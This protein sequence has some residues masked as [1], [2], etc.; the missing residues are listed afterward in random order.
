MDSRMEVIGKFRI[1]LK[2]VRWF[3]CTQS[4]FGDENTKVME[5]K[6]CSSAM[7]L[8]VNE[9]T[10]LYIS[11]SCLQVAY[12]IDD[13]SALALSPLDSSDQPYT[14]IQ[15]TRASLSVDFTNSA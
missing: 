12:E 13:I 6:Q 7:N 3:E 2:E 8:K 4:S 15:Q 5:C 11:L 1:Q 10:G 14:R 9:K